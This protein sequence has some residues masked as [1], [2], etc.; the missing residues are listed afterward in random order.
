M[1]SGNKNMHSE[2]PFPF[3]PS[4]FPVFFSAFF[5]CFWHPKE[6]RLLGRFPCAYKALFYVLS[7]SLDVMRKKKAED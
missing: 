2:H 7:T 6:T 1:D 4:T 3:I 5:C